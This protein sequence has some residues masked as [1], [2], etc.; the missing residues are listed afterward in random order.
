[1]KTKILK[2]ILSATVSTLCLPGIGNSQIFPLSENTWDNP[3]FVKRFL[4]SYGVDTERSP[5]ITTQERDLFNEISGLIGENPQRAAEILS[6]RITSESSA[7][8][9]YT[10]ANIYFQTGNPDR[11]TE[12]Y[13]RA[14]Q[15]FPNFRRAYMN[16]GILKIQQGEFEKA[17]PHLLKTVELGGADGNLYGLIAF[18]HLNLGRSGQALPAYRMARMFAP[19]NKDWAMG[20]IQCLM[21]MSV[22]DEAIVLLDELISRHPDDP[23]LLLLQANA[24]VGKQDLEQA[25][26]NLEMVRSMDAQTLSSLGLLADIYMNMEQPAL[27]LPIYL[28]TLDF[29]E[30]DRQRAFRIAQ[31][32]ARVNAWDEVTAYINSFETRFSESL[33]DSERL[34]VLNLKAEVAL[35]ENRESDAMELLQQVVRRDP[36]NGNALL[37]IASYHW[38]QNAYEEATI[39]FERAEKADNTEVEALIQHAR[40]RVSMREFNRAVELLQRSQ[41][42]DPRSYV[43]DY[44]EM[45]QQ[46]A[47]SARN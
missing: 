34:K 25:V 22:F 6:S 8:L 15:K 28:E 27:A 40:M 10:L 33:S 41:M 36:L 44:L 16:L 7:A 9:D 12:N 38:R 18:S 26:A 45:V 13:K 19:Y 21:N 32:L 23:S 17:L 1:M 2:F 14:I 20:E 3:E 39:Y 47:R 42:L 5:G 29:E 37:L 43:A 35:A 30:L 11:A 31:V 46:A 24:F 4:G